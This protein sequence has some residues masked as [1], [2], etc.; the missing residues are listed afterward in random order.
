MQKALATFTWYIRFRI[1]PL[2]ESKLLLVNRDSIAIIG[3]VWLTQVQ[4]A[5]VQT[6]QSITTYVKVDITPIYSA[7]M[8]C[9]K[10]QS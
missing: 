6:V 4:R 5:T 10:E 3:S 1:R 8:G 9:Q 2:S 7:S